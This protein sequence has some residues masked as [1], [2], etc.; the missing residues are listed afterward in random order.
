MIPVWQSKILLISEGN[1]LRT[2]SNTEPVYIFRI[3]R[4]H[5]LLHEIVL[6]HEKNATY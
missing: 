4:H 1:I 2:D 5:Q 3:V 6:H